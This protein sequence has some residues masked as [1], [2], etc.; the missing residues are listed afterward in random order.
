MQQEAVSMKKYVLW[1][2]VAYIA[3]SA[4]IGGVLIYFNIDSSS[5]GIL[6]TFISA[7]VSVQMFTKDHGRIP[8]KKETWS[9]TWGSWLSSIV[10]TI[11]ILICI[12]AWAFYDTYGQ[13]SMAD[14][15]TEASAMPI[16]LNTIY[17]I[18][19]VVAIVFLVLHGW[20]MVYQIKSI[21]RKL[22]P[23]ARCNK[24]LLPLIVGQ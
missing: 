10:L 22:M 9:V 14:I 20:R 4:I 21:P 19:A 12:I 7:M 24:F 15:E 8:T 17:I 11:I 16:S 3:F 13:V 23:A 5:P 1:F 18:T 6:I 2:L